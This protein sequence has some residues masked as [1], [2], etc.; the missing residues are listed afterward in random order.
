MNDMLKT[1]S[2]WFGKS[3]YG[4]NFSNPNPEYM[5]KKVKVVEKKED[6]PNFSKQ[7]GTLYIIQKLYTRM[8]F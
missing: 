1:G 3:T 6:N 5:A 8:T 2:N 7:Y 4:Q